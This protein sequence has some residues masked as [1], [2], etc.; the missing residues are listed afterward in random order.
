MNY[1]KEMNAFYDLI[2]YNP[3]SSSAV[4]LWYALMHINNKTRWKCEFRVAGTVLRLKS[5]LSETSFKRARL[6]LK[7]KGYID[8]ESKGGNQAP[9]YRMFS[10]IE[11]RDVVVDKVGDTFVQGESALETGSRRG[12]GG[13]NEERSAEDMGA[14]PFAKEKDVFQFYQENFGAMNPFVR[15]ELNESVEE[16][17][18]TL[19]IEAMKRALVRNKISWGFVKGIL[20]SWENKGIRSV[21]AVE[22]EVVEFRTKKQRNYLYSRGKLE[23]IPDW[24]EEQKERKKRLEEQNQGMEVDPEE[25]EAIRLEI[26]RM[27]REMGYEG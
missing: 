20:Q 9:V 14:K 5:G 10:L 22:A 24:F 17:G 7:E 2:E 27:K 4:A 8:Y 15:E 3:L 1:I 13:P 19:V 25:A 11:N 23:I 12:E 18:E 21:Q 6:E 16:V 26:Q